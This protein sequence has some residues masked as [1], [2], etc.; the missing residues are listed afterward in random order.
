[1]LEY[2]EEIAQRL[3]TPGRSSPYDIPP[4]QNRCGER[5]RLYRR[6]VGKS[7]PMKGCTECWGEGGARG[8]LGPRCLK[9]I[10]LDRCRCRC[11]G[12]RYGWIGAG[13]G[14]GFS[15]SVIRLRRRWFLLTLPPLLP[16]RL[17]LLHPRFRG[18]LNGWIG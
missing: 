11:G 13:R 4:S 15:L 6:R 1:M 7:Q 18:A 8:G 17:L 5:R 10:D 16:T 2:R 14:N 3:T 12:S 9:G